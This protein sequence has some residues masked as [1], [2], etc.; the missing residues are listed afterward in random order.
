MFNL[1]SLRT[2]LTLLIT[3]IIIGITGGLTILSIKKEQNY[4]QRA[5]KE[6]GELFLDSIDVML[7]NSLYSLDVNS[8]VKLVQEFNEHQAVIETVRV[9]DAEGRLL[10]ESTEKYLPLN[11]QPDSFGQKIVNHQTILYQQSDDYLVAAKPIIFGQRTVGAI[12]IKLSKEPLKQK[13]AAVRSQGLIIAAVAGSGGILLALFISHSLTVPLNQLI[14]ATHRITT[15]NLSYR[16]HL[17]NKDEFFLLAKEFNQMSDWLEETLKKYQENN[18]KLQHDLF[19]DNLTGLANRVYILQ[20]IEAEIKEKKANQDHCFAVLFLDCD[21]FKVINDSLGHDVGDEVLINIAQR[22]NLCIRKHDIAARLGGDEFVILIKNLS[23]IK[24]VTQ[25]ADRILKQMSEPLILENQQLVITMSIGVVVSQENY[26][27]ADDLLRDADIT[28][29]HAKQQGKAQYAIFKPIMHTQALERLEVESSLRKA[30]EKQEFYLYYQPII[31]FKTS[32]LIGFEA[33]LRWHHPTQGWISP[34]TFIPIA[35]ETGLIV[36]L[37]QWVLQEA[38]HQ[39]SIWQSHFP[40]SEPLKVSVNI[41]S[42]QLNQMDFVE[43]VKK[44]LEESKIKAS[45]LNLEITETVI[46]NNIESTSFKLQCLQKL[47]VKISIDDFGTGYSSLNYLQQLPID[48]LKI[49]RSFVRRLESNPSEFQIIEAI[50]KLGNILGM[51]TLAEGIETSEQYNLIQSLGVDYAQGF[52]FS[53]PLNK[54]LVEQ[55]LYSLFQ[56]SSL[57]WNFNDYVNTISG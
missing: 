14:K 12:A 11:T 55:T 42:F 4:H 8:I 24:Q 27:N 9:F 15:G 46:M 50:I 41:S 51:E 19:H 3:V 39:I 36:S 13:I 40:F 32:Q 44:V 33:L 52:I 20:E 5:I 38:C 34:A 47:G 1:F 7:R 22:L 2:K 16:I 10:I 25:I 37:G 29:Y 23:D 35:E 17:K 28:M 26:E 56:S 43:Q 57:T 49:D 31:S 18:A 21:R 30:L 6:Q 48:I 53:K 45:Q 54:S